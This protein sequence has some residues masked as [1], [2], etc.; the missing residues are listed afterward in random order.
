MLAL[1]LQ[2]LAQCSMQLAE[3][4]GR[5]YA[6]ITA[7]PAWEEIL[8]RRFAAWGASSL[9]RGI[10]LIDRAALEVLSSPLAVLSDVHS[11]MERAKT[12]GAQ[13]YILGGAVFAGFLQH[14]RQA[15]VAAEGALDCLQSALQALSKAVLFRQGQTGPGS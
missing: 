9:F 7:G 4:Q 13:R 15:D 1:G 8:E 11:A 12:R 3:A 6:V 10:E 2:N 14:F 5:P